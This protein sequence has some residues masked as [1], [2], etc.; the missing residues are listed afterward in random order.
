MPPTA[1][2]PL[3][4]VGQLVVLNP[5]AALVGFERLLG[6]LLLA[7][8]QLDPANGLL[9]LAGALEVPLVVG[10][11]LLQRRVGLGLIGRCLN[12]RHSG[13]V[14]LWV[15]QP[16][17]FHLGV[18]GSGV[19]RVAGGSCVCIASRWRSRLTC[20]GLG[21]GSSSLFCLDIGGSSFRGVGGS[22]AKFGGSFGGSTAIAVG[23]GLGNLGSLRFVQVS[24]RAVGRKLRALAGFALGGRRPARQ[25]KD[26][27]SACG[28]AA[29]PLGAGF[30][31][32]YIPCVPWGGCGNCGNRRFGLGFWG[33]IF[34]T[35]GRRLCLRLLRQDVG[36]GRAARACRAGVDRLRPK[37]AW[38]LAG[39]RQHGRLRRLPIAPWRKSRDR[40]LVDRNELGVPAWVFADYK[41]I[42]LRT[43]F[44]DV[45]LRQAGDVAILA[46]H[47][48]PILDVHLIDGRRALPHGRIALGL[49]YV[50]GCGQVEAPVLAPLLSLLLTVA[51][52][53]NGLKGDARRR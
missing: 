1:P 18:S 13:G 5:L 36:G 2:K 17:G 42:T 3:V 51:D 38:L 49:L 20:R 39:S 32:P 29:R 30:V 35:W 24:P 44:V 50:I 6:F 43:K 4:K 53:L 9:Q 41:V 31:V 26:C 14:S 10:V 28:G 7:G 16:I 11:F 12:A 34:L 48:G 15:G 45:A 40:V 8:A 23:D 19:H 25:T 22:T 47:L 27:Q 33:R 46:Q 52:N 21:W 37:A